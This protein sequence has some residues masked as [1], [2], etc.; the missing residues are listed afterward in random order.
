[1]SP[2]GDFSGE[3]TLL[4]MVGDYQDWSPSKLNNQ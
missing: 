4:Y 3:G 1:M 2:D